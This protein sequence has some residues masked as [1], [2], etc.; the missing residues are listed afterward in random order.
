MSSDTG[1]LFLCLVRYGPRSSVPLVGTWC[2]PWPINKVFDKAGNIWYV[3]SCSVLV[4]SGRRG[5]GSGIILTLNIK[6]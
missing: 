6:L 1:G 2:G 4:N 5:G 3:R